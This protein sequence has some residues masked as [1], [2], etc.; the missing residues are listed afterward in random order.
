MTIHEFKNQSWLHIKTWCNELK[1]N[2]MTLIIK[3]KDTLSIYCNNWEHFDIAF[4]NQ[5]VF[6]NIIYFNIYFK[7]LN[8]Y[9]LFI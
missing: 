3:L 6:L 9:T 2:V 8:I 1:N 5:I 4:K 7:L